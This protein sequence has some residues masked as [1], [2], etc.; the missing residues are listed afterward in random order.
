MYYMLGTADINTLTD[1]MDAFTFRKG[2]AHL[3]TFPVEF[4]F[5]FLLPIFAFAGNAI[6]A[7]LGMRGV[8]L[9]GLAFTLIHQ[10]YAPYWLVPSNSIE[11]FEYLPAFL[12]GVVGAIA[13]IYDQTSWL[14]KRAAFLGGVIL[15]GIL[16]VTPF[17]W[18]FRLGLPPTGYLLDKYLDFS[19]AWTILIVSQT[20][21][22]GFLRSLWTSRILTA[23][24]V[25][26]Y[27]IY[28]IHW[29]VLNKLVE[30]YPERVETSVVVVAGSIGVGYLM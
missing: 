22:Q 16:I 11:T 24:G 6:H 17:M 3:W 12:F 26:S 5:Y 9:S 8:L 7:R 13:K 29:L 28:L 27:S 25:Y 1:V 15:S 21:S 2:Y 20:H 23:I 14:T 30:Y 18:A 10:I 19:L 4:K